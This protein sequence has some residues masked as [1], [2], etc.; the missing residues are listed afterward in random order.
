MQTS[1]AD[2]FAA[3]DAAEVQESAS[4]RTFL[5]SQWYPAREQ[6]K[7]AG[8]N[9]AGGSML[10]RKTTPFSVTRLTDIQTAIMGSVGWESHE[11]AHELAHGE[12]EAW[13]LVTNALPARVRHDINR[14]RILVGEK[15][16]V[17]AVVMGDQ[18]LSHPLFRYIDRQVDISTIRQALLQPDAQVLQILADYWHNEVN[19]DARTPPGQ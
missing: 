11:G 16:L 10:Y 14:S 9:M 5:Y 2:I 12:D 3:G 15:T 18:T 19:K 13:K 7:V 4:G 17:G 8:A 6:G 1:Q